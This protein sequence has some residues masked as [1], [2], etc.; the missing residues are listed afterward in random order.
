[1]IKA[2]ELVEFMRANPLATVATISADGGPEAATVGVAVSDRLELV[3]DTLDTSRKFLNVKGEPR[4]AAVFG[5]AGA[6]RSGKHDERTLQYEG[7]ADIPG[8]DELKRAQEDIYF[9]Q[10]PDGRSRMKWA[11]VAY[12]RVTPAWIRYSDY[13]A[14]PPRILELRGEELAKFIAGI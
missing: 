11:H 8:G 14:S 9:K 6:Y 4:I 5:A 10:F 2:N 7:F 3:F 1:V 13:N 12:V